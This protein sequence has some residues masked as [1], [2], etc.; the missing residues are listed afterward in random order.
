MKN[1][2]STQFFAGSSYLIVDRGAFCIYIYSTVL[3]DV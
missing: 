1:A 3:S 2:N